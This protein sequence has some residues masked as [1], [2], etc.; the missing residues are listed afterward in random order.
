LPL[1]DSNPVQVVHV[2][3]KWSLDCEI[4]RLTVDEG[5]PPEVLL[6]RG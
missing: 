6:R 1:L 3:V 5:R 2:Q 4:Q